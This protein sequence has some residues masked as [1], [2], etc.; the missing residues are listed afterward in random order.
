VQVA[1][2]IIPLGMGRHA[3]QCTLGIVPRRAKP[4]RLGHPI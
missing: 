4:A 2:A 3:E 1:V